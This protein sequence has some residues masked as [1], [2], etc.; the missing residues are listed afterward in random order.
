METTKLMTI[1]DLWELDDD[2]CR[3]ELIRGELRSISP[4]GGTHGELLYTLIAILAAQQAHQQARIYAGD[5]G[6]IIN[7]DAE[8]I[9]APDL[10]IVH[11]DRLPG[12]ERI[13]GFLSVIPDLVIEILSPSDRIGRV[14]EKVS[15]Y[16][17]A[18]VQIIWLV[19]P[20]RRTVTEYAP[21][22]PVRLCQASDTLTAEAVLPG[23]RLAVDDIFSL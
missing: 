4:T 3:H 19:D 9:L 22:Q 16:L 11:N 15:L 13:S 1:K 17:D 20:D 5:T 23:F 8:T 12:G 14:N 2:G 7:R 18:G 10:A 21:G 6:F